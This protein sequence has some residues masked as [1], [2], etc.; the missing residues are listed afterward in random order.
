MRNAIAPKCGPSHQFVM[1]PVMIRKELGEMIRKRQDVE[2]A[3]AAA[4]MP[5]RATTARQFGTP[6]EPRVGLQFS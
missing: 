4:G 6:L 3:A 1:N 2:M 5:I